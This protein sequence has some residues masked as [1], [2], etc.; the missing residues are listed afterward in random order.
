M[1]NNIL[2]TPGSASITFSGSAANTIRL[3]VEPSG[4]LA[5]YGNAGSLFGI[6]DSLSGSLMSVNDI[7]GLPILEVFSDDRVVMGTYATPALTVTG[8]VSNFG[9]MTKFEE[10]TELLNTKTGATG[11]VTHDLSTG[12]VFYHSSISANFTINITNV[13]TTNNRTI[14]VTLIL[15]QGATGYYPNALQ[16]DGSAQTIRWIG[17]ETPTPS[18]SKID[19]VTFSLIRVSST[20]YVLGQLAAF[21]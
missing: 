4:N 15:N 13:P 14:V 18:T 3:Q 7:S 16:I 21:A 8:S 20:W 6:T 12:A 1:P 17:N 19:V 9:G 2:I 10:I 5:F 11:T